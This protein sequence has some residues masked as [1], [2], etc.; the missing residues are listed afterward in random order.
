[1]HAQESQSPTCPVTAYTQPVQL[2]GKPGLRYLSYNIGV[3]VSHFYL[4]ISSQ[5]EYYQ[6]MTIHVEAKCFLW[7]LC[8][9]FR[10]L[11]RVPE[12]V[13]A[14][15]LANEMETYCL[16]SNIEL[17][18]ALL[19]FCEYYDFICT[20]PTVWVLHYLTTSGASC[21]SRIIGV[22]ATKADGVT[23]VESELGGR[24][25]SKSIYKRES[26][27]NVQY[28][29]SNYSLTELK[30]M[31]DAFDAWEGEGVS[32]WQVPQE[33]IEYW[34]LEERTLKGSLQ[35]MS[36]V[37]K[38]YVLIRGISCEGRE[39]T[40]RTRPNPITFSGPSTSTRI[41]VKNSAS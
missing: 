10:G 26:E 8:S 7:T 37:R 36:P 40:N 6:S 39:C 1:M 28:I 17:K 12:N 9:L 20:K 11:S 5:E 16:R 21:E 41:K 25:Y 35:N 23:A 38:R 24:I 3:G 30:K 19:D 31:M 22:Y 33:L 27:N 4:R 14:D 18:K 13:L 32:Y 29:W 34:T 15:H 2:Q